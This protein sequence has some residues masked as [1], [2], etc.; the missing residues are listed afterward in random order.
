MELAAVLLIVSVLL[1]VALVLLT[2]SNVFMT[3]A[4]YAHLKTL[5]QK[6]WIVAALVS[7][8]IALFEYLLQVPANRAGTVDA[9]VLAAT[10]AGPVRFSDSG[11]LVSLPDAVAFLLRPIVLPAL[12]E[13]VIPPGGTLRQRIRQ[14]LK[15]GYSIVVLSEGPP[16]VPAHLSRFRLDTFDAAVQ[17]STLIYPL[18]VRGTS[19]ILSMGR[20]MP[21]HGEAKITLGEPIVSQVADARELVVLREQ[22]RE[23][24]AKLCE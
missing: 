10:V 8:G 17:T 21:A 18:G 20:R 1:V 16:T 12:R 4:W 6:P 11:A 14:G 15:E 2:L 9:L 23:A 3:F 22:V 24:I 7:W 19:P 5:S 13:V